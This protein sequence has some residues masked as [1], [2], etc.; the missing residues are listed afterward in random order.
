[1]Q[2]MARSLLLLAVFVAGCIGATRLA[3]SRSSSATLQLPPGTSTI[4]DDIY[5][6]RTD[7]A[8]ACIARQLVNRAIVRPPAAPISQVSSSCIAGS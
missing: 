6:A 4:L 8:A 5:S 1:M 3:L 7:A 2:R